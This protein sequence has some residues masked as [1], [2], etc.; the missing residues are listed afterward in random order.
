MPGTPRLIIHCLLVMSPLL[1]CLKV[2]FSS[3]HLDLSSQASFA[4]SA[5]GISILPRF[6]PRTL[7]SD[8]SLLSHPTSSWIRSYV[9]STSKYDPEPTI[10]CDPDC[11][12]PVQVTILPFLDNCSSF[13]T[14][15]P[16]STLLSGYSQHSSQ[17]NPYEAKSEPATPLP[18]I[19]ENLPTTLNGKSSP[20]H[21]QKPCF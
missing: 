20:T 6:Q 4:V 15:F 1:G 16:D 17:D 21:A 11:H 2:T 19:F 13:Q 3:A 18:Y 14:G 5:N 7:N 12:C 8:F 10:S 9:H